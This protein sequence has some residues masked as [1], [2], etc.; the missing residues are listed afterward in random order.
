MA[1]SL[2]NR[3][4]VKRR[5]NSDINVTPLVDVMLVLLI[6]FMITAPMLVGGVEVDLPET[7]ADAVA[8]QYKPLVV[9][10]SKDN[11]IYL[12]DNE[13]NRRDIIAKLKNIAKEKQDTRIF[14]KGDK[15]VPYGIV[16]E[17]MV[18]IYKAGFTKVSLISE[19]KQ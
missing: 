7:N 15:E 9:T 10:I 5:L 19:I 16:A 2:N 17:T 6:I 12:F 1:L 18:E 14:V 4:R 8:G 3:G 13:I 11:K